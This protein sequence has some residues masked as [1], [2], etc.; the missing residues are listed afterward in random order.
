MPEMT[1]EQRAVLAGKA[2]GWYALKGEYQK[3]VHAELL[4]D[5]LCDLRH[6][7]A[8]VGVDFEVCDRNARACFEAEV[9]EEAD[10]DR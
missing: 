6:W 3:M 5:L 9:R 1:N 4:G 2:V 10:D 8:K 7:A